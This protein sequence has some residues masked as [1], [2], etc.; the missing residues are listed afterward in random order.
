MNSKKLLLFGTMICL[1]SGCGAQQEKSNA[2]YEKDKINIE[3]T[4][5]LQSDTETNRTETAG[6][7]NTKNSKADKKDF[8]LTSDFGQPCWQYKGTS[9]LVDINTLD[10]IGD[11][12]CFNMFYEFDTDADMKLV[13][14]T[15]DIYAENIFN[16]SNFGNIDLSEFDV[17]LATETVTIFQNTTANEV[18]F[19]TNPYYINA[20]KFS[21]GYDSIFKKLDLSNIIATDSQNLESFLKKCTVDDLTIGTLGGAQIQNL[22]GAFMDCI[23]KNVDFSNLDLSNLISANRVFSGSKIE[24]LNISNWNITEFDEKTSQVSNMFEDA[25]IKT[26]IVNNQQDI[27]T[28]QSNIALETTELILK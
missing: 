18:N 24:T 10:E 7:K 23:I 26:I 1:L 15:K 17:S 5:I 8:E 25:K 2:S 13:A 4:D 22:D 21:I 27:D 9:N 6:N 16:Y 11:Y 28:L 12:N 14:T 20:S 3:T 19:G